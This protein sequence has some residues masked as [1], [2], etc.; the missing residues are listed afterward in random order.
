MD[1]RLQEK[2]FHFKDRDY[3]LRCNMN[4]IADVQ[5]ACGGNIFRVI[6]DKSTLK[7]VLV[8]LAAMMNDYADEQ[9]WEDYTP[10]TG[11]SLG[12]EI[13]IADIPHIDILSLVRSA[14]FAEKAKGAD[15]DESD[16]S[17][18]ESSKN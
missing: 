5:E 15:A 12:R 14:L 1:I 11:R 16:G 18:E 13:T 10:Y 6:D 17:D 7:G 3:V 2:K 9:G 4:V 8:W